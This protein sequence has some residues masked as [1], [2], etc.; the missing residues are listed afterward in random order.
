MLNEAQINELRTRYAAID[1]VD[2]SG[3]TYAKMCKLL[4]SLSQDDLKTL[5]AAKIKF[6]SMLARNR[7]K[8]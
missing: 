6:I 7:V 3:P 4:N 8:G 2:P 5:A 1:R